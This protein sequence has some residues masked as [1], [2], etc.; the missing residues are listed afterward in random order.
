[1]SEP[2]TLPL[3][4]MVGRTAES[5]KELLGEPSAERR[6]GAD[7]WLV[8]RYPTLIV[9]LRCR[10]APGCEEDRVASWTATFGTART[11]LREAAGPLGLWPACAPDARAGARDGLLRR[12]L[13]DPAAAMPRSLTASVRQGS[14]RTISVFDEPPEWTGPEREASE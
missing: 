14:I 13:A 6:I 7:R 8:Y 2:P 1:M 5:A 10:R 4:G 3:R 9:R 11:S 12:A